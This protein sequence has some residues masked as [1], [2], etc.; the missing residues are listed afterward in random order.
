MVFSD[1][2]PSDLLDVVAERLRRGLDPVERS[3]L[4]GEQSLEDPDRVLVPGL[5]LR[6]GVALQSEAVPGVPEVPDV[7][8]E[9]LVLASERLHLSAA[10]LE[11]LPEAFLILLEAPEV[12]VELDVA[13]AGAGVVCPELLSFSPGGVL[14]LEMLRV[15]LHQLLVVNYARL[16]PLAEPLEVSRLPDDVVLLL[17]GAQLKLRDDM[18]EA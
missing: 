2:R 17:V 4:L 5:G 10:P 14:V 6:H 15:V 12:D 16:V 9:E 18:G 1:V 13:V 11:L 3:R 8:D 7:G